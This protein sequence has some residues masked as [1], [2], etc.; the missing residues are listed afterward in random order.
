ME[1]S[2]L[3]MISNDVGMWNMADDPERWEK[4]DHHGDKIP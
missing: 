3:A 2:V 4:A 1:R